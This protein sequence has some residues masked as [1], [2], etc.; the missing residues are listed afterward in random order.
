[1][2]GKN[3][4]LILN[5]T[6]FRL[7]LV[8]EI[9]NMK[10]LN[11]T[12]AILVAA[13]M[14][15]NAQT[16]TS[17]VVGYQT[18]AAAKGY[19]TLGF[20]LVNSPVVSGTVSSKTASS[21]DLNL[22]CP[23]TVNPS[24]PYYLEVTSGPLAGER[25]DVSVTPGSATVGI[26]ASSGNTD[27]LSTLANGASVVVRQHV[28]LGQVDQSCSPA[29]VAGDVNGDRVLFFIGGSFIAYFKD[30]DGLWY[31]DGGFDDMTNMPVRPGVGLLLQRKANT[32]TTVTQIGTVRS[33]KFARP[34]SAG[35]QVYAPAYPVDLTPDGMGAT[36]ANGWRANSNASLADR[37]LTFTGG[38][39]I[40]N[41]LDSSD[42]SWYEDGGFDPLNTTVLLP[43]AKSVVVFKQVA[44][45]GVVE[46][47]PVA[48]Q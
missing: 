4:P 34:Y 1:V 15:G 7:S 45:D 26:V 17:E 38:S 10:K 27:T 44:S 33:N 41:F 39:F 42:N 35:Y 20:P 25:V 18:I 14:A 9:M 28:T 3:F 6:W 30:T 23:S 24:M 12:L 29:L 31:E 21:I 36:V 40:S 11:V 2:T 16:V 5:I 47:S 8:K 32:A 22:V 37:I 46:T 19:T 13:V 43:S 48:V